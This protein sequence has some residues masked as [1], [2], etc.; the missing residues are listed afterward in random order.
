MSTQANLTNEEIF[1]A[2]NSGKKMLFF[3]AGW[4][5]DCAFIK[6]AMPDIMK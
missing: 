4:C 1:E 3:T 2:M 5:P 6:P